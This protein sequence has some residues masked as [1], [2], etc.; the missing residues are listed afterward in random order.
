[1]NIFIDC[2][3]GV[4]SEKPSAC[5]NEGDRLS[6]VIRCFRMIIDR[7]PQLAVSIKPLFGILVG[8]F[9]SNAF[10]GN[11]LLVTS[12]QHF[13]SHLHNELQLSYFGG[14]APGRGAGGRAI[15]GCRYH[16]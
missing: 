13:R 9:T 15:F 4:L 11:F 1:M 7:A 8:H 5:P 12:I 16:G 14:F 6:H 3:H 2:L 10:V